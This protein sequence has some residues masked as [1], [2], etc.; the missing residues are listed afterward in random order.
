MIRWYLL[1]FLLFNIFS[2]TAQ[3]KKDDFVGIWCAYGQFEVKVNDTLEFIEGEPKN[4]EVDYLVWEFRSNREVTQRSF[5]KVYRGDL[6]P[7]VT[8]IKWKNKKW[9]Y[10]EET[11]VLFIDDQKYFVLTITSSHMVVVREK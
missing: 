1:F 9:K 10:F 7:V 5:E 8:E 2:T 4:S 6:P 3:I 11:K